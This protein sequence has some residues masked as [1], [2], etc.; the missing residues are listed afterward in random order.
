MMK[1]TT[2]MSW[3][4]ARALHWSQFIEITFFESFDFILK[5]ACGCIIGVYC[6]EGD[7]CITGI[8]TYRATS[9]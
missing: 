8:I 5:V 6:E 9:C 2:W 1:L 3:G 7:E 4:D